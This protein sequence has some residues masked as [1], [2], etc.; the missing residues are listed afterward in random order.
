MKRLNVVVL[1][2]SMLLMFSYCDQNDD[3]SN[4]EVADEKIRSELIKLNDAL[5]SDEYKEQKDGNERTNNT[6]NENARQMIKSKV[7]NRLSKRNTDCILI[8]SYT[9]I[10]EGG[11]YKFTR[12]ETDENWVPLKDCESIINDKEEY[13]ERLG[14][15]S[16][17][18]GY[19][20]WVGEYIEKGGVS[21]ESYKDKGSYEHKYEIEEYEDEIDSAYG[22]WVDG[23]LVDGYL[24]DGYL[25]DG[26]WVDDYWVDDYWVDSY[27]VDDYWVD[28]YWVE[29]DVSSTEYVDEYS[30]NYSS[31]YDYKGES[32]I[33]FRDRNMELKIIFEDTYYHE[34]VDGK[35]DDTSISNLT[36][37]FDLEDIKYSFRISEEDFAAV[38]YDEYEEYEE[39]EEYDEEMNSY[40]I[41][42]VKLYRS[43]VHVGYASL[44]SDLGI[45]ILDMDKNELDS[46]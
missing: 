8:S 24:E 12:T 43:E 36:F 20:T 27:W 44:Y 5:Q 42:T 23:Y 39:Y 21:R 22:Y 3:T 11:I 10:I 37:S 7:L 25:E 45:K 17:T 35:E 31:Y 41:A 9:E 26:Y 32:N 6:K 19:D 4:S 15:V 18:R 13:D 29:Y 14:K 2:V 33:S 40:I 16:V 1:V 30:L 38:E 34:Y 28:G 46:N